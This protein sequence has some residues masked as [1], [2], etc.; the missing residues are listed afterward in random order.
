ME[1]RMNQFMKS[2]IVTAS[3]GILV[4]SA[5]ACSDNTE[6]QD[7]IRDQ[8][9]AIDQSYEAEADLEEALADGGPN[10]EAVGE[11]ADALRE[12]GERTEDQLKESAEELDD[13]PQ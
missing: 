5:S 1:M 10:E 8:A 12:K 4:L 2:C 9:E 7:Q 13:V 11:Y 6:A 3:A